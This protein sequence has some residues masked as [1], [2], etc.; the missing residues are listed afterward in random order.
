MGF[1]NES[2]DKIFPPSN[3][4]II[5]FNVELTDKG[6]VQCELFQMYLKN[7]SK[8]YVP[9]SFSLSQ[10][11]NKCISFVLKSRRTF[12]GWNARGT[13]HL[14]LLIEPWFFL[15]H[16][17]IVLRVPAYIMIDEGT[18]YYCLVILIHFSGSYHYLYSMFYY[19]DTT[20][21]EVYQ[22]K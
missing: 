15:T 2:I 18:R 5:D 10:I 4:M 13:S 19:Y 11:R 8:D 12:A 1:P 9:V 7:S 6:R 3:F 21:I 17:L 22:R 16:I 14:S 20:S